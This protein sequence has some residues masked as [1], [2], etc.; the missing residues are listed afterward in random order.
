MEGGQVEGEEDRGS[1]RGGGERGW[2]WRGCER[3][4]VE[5]IGEGTEGRGKEKR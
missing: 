1:K 2:D 4:V 5:E 3:G